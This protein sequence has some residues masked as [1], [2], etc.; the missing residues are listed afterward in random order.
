LL[1][2][3]K[4]ELE[5]VYNGAKRGKEAGASIFIAVANVDSSSILSQDGKVDVE[6]AEVRMV[7]GEGEG[8]LEFIGPKGFDR[9]FR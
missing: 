5:F 3:S 9:R 1:T 7:R 8:V 6:F 2:A 4:G